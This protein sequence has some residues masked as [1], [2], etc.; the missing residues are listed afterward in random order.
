MVPE[1]VDID[2]RMNPHQQRAARER[3]KSDVRFSYCPTCRRYRWL[4][5]NRC[6]DCGCS[7]EKGGQNG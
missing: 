3:R 4:E 7:A 2:R 1:I 5:D 6:R